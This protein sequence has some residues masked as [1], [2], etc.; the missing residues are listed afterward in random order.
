MSYATLQTL[1]LED[2]AVATFLAASFGIVVMALFPGLFTL[3][4]WQTCTFLACGWALASDR[5]P[6]TTY[7][8]RTG[9]PAAKPFSQCSGFLGCPR[10]NK[11]WHLWGAVIRLAAPLVPEGAGMRLIFDD[12]TKKKAGTHSEGLGHSR[13]GAGSAR[14]AYR[15][16]RGVNC[17]LGMRRIPLTPGPGHCLSVPVGLELYLTPEH[18]PKLNVPYR[19][20]SQLARDLLDFVAEQLPGRQ[21]RSLADGGSAPKDYVRQLPKAA[22]GVGRFPISAQLYQ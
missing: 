12:T 13:N 19:S 11:R 22:H 14:Q 20:R 16:L 4:S 5:H 9:A 3:P 18:A 10:Y 7:L 1:L 2:S 21:L 15:T 6:I 8:W 17:V